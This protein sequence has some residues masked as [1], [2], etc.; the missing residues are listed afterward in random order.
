[1]KGFI[2][3]QKTREYLDY[4]EK[5]LTNVN[6]AFEEVS[7][8]CHNLP[9]IADYDSWSSIRDDVFKHDLSKFSKEE[10]VQ[11]REFFYPVEN[12]ETNSKDMDE[13]WEHH[14][15]S[16]NHHWE[17]MLNDIDKDKYPGTVEQR[18][19][20]MVIDWLAMSYEFGDTPRKYYEQ[21][22]NKI[23]LPSK[24]KEFML[25]VFDKLESYRD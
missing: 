9:V 5:H 13:A 20:L 8:S 14:K 1:M 17:T 16:N 15:I 25:I 2:Y 18:V 12:E 21:N 23:K 10:F 6:K 19:V 7:K 11:Y 24:A 4:I 22:A 3:I